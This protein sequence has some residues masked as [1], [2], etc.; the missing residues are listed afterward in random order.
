VPASWRCGGFPGSTSGSGTLA[1]RTSRQS[2][3]ER[4]H[5]IGLMTDDGHHGKGEHD[6]RD[7]PVPTVPGACL[8]VIETEF[9]L[10]GF[11]AVLN[12]PAMTFDRRELFQG[13][14]LGAPCG[15]EG[16]IAIGNIAADKKTP[17]PFSR[18]GAVV[19]AGIEIGQFEIG[20]VM[21]AWPFGSLP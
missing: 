10:G 18:E 7:M 6:E 2:F 14:A 21:Q 12:G 5:G 17:R 4:R 20:P 16:K 9:V 11:E 15:E 8:I 1:G 13:R 3:F 19:F